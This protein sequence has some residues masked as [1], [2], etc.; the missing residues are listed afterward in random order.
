MKGLVCLRCGD[1]FG[2]AS[3]R[4]LQ[5]GEEWAGL[6]LGLVRRWGA[7]EASCRRGLRRGEASGS[8]SFCRARGL[9]HGFAISHV[10]RGRRQGRTWGAAA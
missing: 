10:L 5:R 2:A 4:I 6:F 8:S 1:A 3:V 9:V 7:L